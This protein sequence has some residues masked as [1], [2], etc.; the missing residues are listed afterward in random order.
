MMLRLFIA[1]LIVLPSFG[2]DGAREGR[3]GN[4]FYENGQFEEAAEAYR[5][6]LQELEEGDAPAMAAR[7]WNNLGAALHRLERHEEAHKA[8]ENALSAA[9]ADED[10]VRAAYN[11]GNNEVARGNLEAALDFYE[12]T[13]LADPSH[14]DA[15]YNYEFVKRRLEQESE[16]PQQN[17]QQEDI[18]PSDYAKRLK[19]QAEALVEQEQ[20]QDAH[21]LMMEGLKKDSTVQ[22]F[23]SF[24]TRVR[25]VSQIDSVG[26]AVQ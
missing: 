8:F 4:A 15:R 24:I 25:D 2:G 14:E 26:A 19:A 22:A 21:D 16:Q 5:A 13:L 3:Q 1:L 9:D 6:G 12:R 20:Y 11:A 17:Q 23:Q 10:R 18:E 7:L